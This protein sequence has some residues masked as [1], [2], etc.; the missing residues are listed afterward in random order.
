MC[1][2]CL[3][4][5]HCIQEMAGVECLDFFSAANK[6]PLICFVVVFVDAKITVNEMSIPLGGI[7]R[8]FAA[9]VFFVLN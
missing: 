7:L 9:A 8:C 2:A 3:S 6:L 1:E 4:E 5:I